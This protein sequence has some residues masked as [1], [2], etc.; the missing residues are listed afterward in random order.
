MAHRALLSLAL[1]A[2]WFVSLPT[3]A[4][5]PDATPE[6]ARA[7]ARLVQNAGLGD[8][9]GID[10]VRLHD[11]KSLYQRHADRP[12]NPA[13]NQKLLTSAAALWR[14]GPTFRASTKVEG[15]L[16]GGRVDRLVLRASGDPSLGYRGLFALAQALR[17]RGVDYVEQIV[18]DESYFDVQ[19]L[20]PAFDQQPNEPAAFRAAI[21]AFSVDRNSY[22]VHVGPGPAPGEPG[23]VR[24]L[25]DDYIVVENKTTTKAS[26]PPRLQID[27]KELPDGRLQVVVRGDVPSA[28]RTLYYR[29]RIP[30]P[31]AHAATLW[32]RALRQ[33]GMRGPL[34]VEHA[35]VGE[36]L[37]VLADMSSSEL[38][39]MLYSVGKWSDNFAA[40]M[41]LKIIA[42]EDVTP[43]T[44]ARGA[45]LVVE[46]LQ[47]HGVD[48]EGLVLVNGSGLFDGNRV[49]P[50]HVA[51]TLVAAYGDPAIRSEYVAQLA[52]GGADG[53]LQSR[54]KRLPRGRM[55]R[56]KTGTLRDVIAL[57][58]YVLGQPNRSVAF[59]FLANGIAGKQAQARD[60]ADAIV[61]V[62][63]EYALEPDPGGD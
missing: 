54:L 23:R 22:T 5:G 40:E 13:S 61:A 24:V 17:L 55:V 21:S 45:E 18:V 14:L 53:T 46:E 57:S 12:L 9:V 20:P 36:R 16:R 6:V 27:H 30:D 15:V 28:V 33:A 10:V 49:S 60:L 25:A 11:G 39:T 44:S 59:S 38:S 4:D 58:G 50:R 56:A 32:V 2:C 37:P 31:R 43:G 35:T 62:L 47:K 1:I 8:Q 7:I 3:L 19:T 48:V 41:V 63:A 34:R 29:R 52:V 42:A 51:D 26:G